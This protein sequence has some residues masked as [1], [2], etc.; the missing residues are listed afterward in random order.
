M[1]S[2][3]EWKTVISVAGVLGAYLFPDVPCWSG[4]EAWLLLAHYQDRT[5]RRDYHPYWDIGA[6]LGGMDESLDDER[7]LTH[8]V[9]QL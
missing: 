2:W 9:A 5:E 8:A 6:A 4:F 1:R 7:F 3:S